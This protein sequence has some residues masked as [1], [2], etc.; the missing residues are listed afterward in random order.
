MFKAT[1]VVW[2]LLLI[3]SSSTYGYIL[4]IRSVSVTSAPSSELDIGDGIGSLCKTKTELFYLCPFLTI[5][6][7]LKS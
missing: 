1:T 7:E 5:A 6:C 4:A 3:Q 2:P